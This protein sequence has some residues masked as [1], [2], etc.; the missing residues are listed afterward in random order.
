MAMTSSTSST[1]PPIRWLV[2]T[3]PLTADALFTEKPE[4]FHQTTIKRRPNTVSPTALGGGR[5]MLGHRIC[6]AATRQKT[7][8]GTSERI[9]IAHSQ[10]PASLDET[11]FGS[12]NARAMPSLMRYSRQQPDGSTPPAQQ[13]ADGKSGTETSKDGVRISSTLEY[14][15]TGYSD[16]STT[17]AIHAQYDCWMPTKL[18]NAICAHTP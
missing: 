4:R 14:S 2:S 13:L 11:T 8:V 6:G 1:V 16:K 3:S 15:S 17:P 7:I 10:R 18:P 5:A 9:P 12:V